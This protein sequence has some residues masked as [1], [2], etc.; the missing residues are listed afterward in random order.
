M[1]IKIHG[2]IFHKKIVL[3]RP[4]LRIKIK[5]NKTTNKSLR[6]KLHRKGYL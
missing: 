6:I 5:D 1:K 2:N 4:K 3:K